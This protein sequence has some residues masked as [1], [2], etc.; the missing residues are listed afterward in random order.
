[1]SNHSLDYENDLVPNY[2]NF[3]VQTMSLSRA[4][5]LREN[6]MKIDIG[7]FTVTMVPYPLLR[8]DENAMAF[9]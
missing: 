5:L 8:G 1:M 4:L 6:G 3:I 7:K 2:E 9:G